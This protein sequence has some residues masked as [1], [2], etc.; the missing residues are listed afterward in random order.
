MAIP[1]PTKPPV[2]PPESPAS[3]VAEG[4]AT[5]LVMLGGL[6]VMAGA[7][8]LGDETDGATGVEVSF[9]A[10]SV[11]VSFL[12][13][14]SSE[15]TFL[16]VGVVFGVVVAFVVV[17]A[18]KEMFSLSVMGLGITVEKPFGFPEKVWGAVT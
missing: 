15:V 3:A 13:S 1:P 6:C 8:M 9:D 2:A 12:S 10:T 11:S 7:A 18:L 4:E 14:S 5:V 17:G 16:A